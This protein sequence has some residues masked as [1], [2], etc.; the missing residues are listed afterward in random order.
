MCFSKSNFGGTPPK[1]ETGRV[2]PPSG[3]SKGIAQIVS[4]PQRLRRC[5]PYGRVRLRKTSPG[6]F[7]PLRVTHETGGRS[8]IAPTI[9]MEDTPSRCGNPFIFGRFVKRSYG[10]KSKRH[11]VRPLNEGE[12]HHSRRAGAC[13][14]RF[15]RT[16]PF[17][18]AAHKAPPYNKIRR[19]VRSSLVSQSLLDPVGEGSP[20]PP[21]LC[22]QKREAKRLPY[23]I[24]L[25]YPHDI[26]EGKC[27]CFRVLREAPLLPCNN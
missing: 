6:C 22:D 3:G 4:R 20:L 13:S 10:R 24:F 26:C 23:T 9:D 27:V 16:M 15:I 7:S 21:I 5:P 19:F 25:F 1:R 8:M 17:I 14:R 12:N 11:R 18:A 2:T